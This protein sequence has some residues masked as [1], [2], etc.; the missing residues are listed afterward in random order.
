MPP[1]YM[2]LLVSGDLVIATGAG[3]LARRSGKNGRVY[4][5]KPGDAEINGGLINST[6][7]RFVETMCQVSLLLTDRH[8][9][10]ERARQLDREALRGDHDAR[11]AT[12]GRHAGGREPRIDRCLLHPD[13]LHVREGDGIRLPLDGSEERVVP[14]RGACTARGRTPGALAGNGVEL[15]HLSTPRRDGDDRFVPV[16]GSRLGPNDEGLRRGAPGEIE[17]ERRL[18]YVA[19]TRAKDD[20][21]LV[22]PHRFYT[23]SQAKAGDRHVYA[24]RTRFIPHALAQH[25]E[26]AT[27][28]SATAA[29]GTGT[30]GP[31]ARVDVGSKLRAMWS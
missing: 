3:G 29:P 25:F 30:S 31:R 5:C 22:V 13:V 2:D 4:W 16:F 8:P 21:H 17:E 15:D 11:P 7:E 19:M 1:V 6:L 28:S 9:E 12:T 23:H 27:W 18:L 24:P 26:M 20:L 14:K 10:D